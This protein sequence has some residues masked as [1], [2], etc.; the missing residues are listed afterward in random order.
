MSKKVNFV[1]IEDDEKTSMAVEVVGNDLLRVHVGFLK[2]C[3]S[4]R[5]E[6][7]LPAPVVVSQVLNKITDV[8]NG[9]LCKFEAVED[10]AIAG[11]K[12]IVLLET[13][14]KG[15]FQDQ[16]V[17]SG[18]G[19][20]MKVVFEASVLGADDGTPLLKDGIH[21]IGRTTMSIDD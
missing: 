7:P 19:C 9:P 10:D 14:E 4:Y 1:H 11:K 8:N 17:F 2:D 15:S 13:V 21:L 5:L 3:H 6:V 20:S 16:I 12:M 18:I